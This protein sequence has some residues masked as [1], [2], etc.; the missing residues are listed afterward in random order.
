MNQTSWI[1]AIPLL[2]GTGG[3]V[4][5]ASP[6]E[7]QDIGKHT[8]TGDAEITDIERSPVAV[9]VVDAAKFH[10]R[11]ISLNELLKRVA[12]VKVRQQGGLGSKSTIAIHGLEGKRIKIFVDGRPLNSPDGTFGIN[13]IP[14]QLI[15]R[16]EVYKGVVP[17]RF[18]GDSLGG[19]VNVVTREFE[20]SQVDVTYALGSY[21]MH[22]LAG[23]VKK[24]V[25]EQGIEVAA[26]GFFNRAANDYVMQSPYA[27]GLSIRRDHDAYEAF[28]VATGM[29]FHD[30]LFD[31][32]SFELVRYESEKEIQGIDK[33]IREAET[34][35]EVNI[36][37][38]QMV[39]EDLWVPG[40]DVELTLQY[41]DLH[42]HLDDQATTCY[43]FAGNAF[44]CPGAG[45][46]VNGIPHD[47]DDRQRD[48]RQD[49]HVDYR[50][51]R[52]NALGF[53]INRQH[54]DYEPDDPLASASLGYD[55]GAFPSEKTNTVYS[56]GWIST[57]LDDQ[58]I[59]DI[60]VKS[61]HYDYRITS[62]TRTLS[63]TPAQTHHSGSEFGYYVSTRYE[64]VPDLF[65]KASYEHAYR[66][67]SS[68]EI[69]GDGVSVVAASDL[70]PEQA[71]NV[72]LGLIFDRHNV[73]GMPWLKAEANVFYRDLQ[74]MI[75]LESGLLTASYVNLGEVRST[76]FEVE[77]QADLSESWYAYLNYTHQ[78]LKDRMK[79]RADGVANPTY[80]K[81]VPN[82]PRQ[83]GNLGLEY[84]HLG[85]WREDALFKVFWE[86]NWA[87]EYFYGWEL[88]RQQSRRIDAQLTHTAGVEYS[89]MDDSLILGLEVR[90]LGD[91]DVTDVFNY[92]LPGRTWHL[93]VRYTWLDF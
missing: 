14:V 25:E 28:T 74:D 45:G 51:S 86:M 81:S 42:S 67:P 65:L 6:D 31:E 38:A 69:F 10:G 87:D 9:S 23:V 22:R 37:G 77:V 24:H 57:V 12:G 91:E 44:T 47:S 83:F 61:Y 49:L 32:M 18:G 19:A 66:L 40:L 79:R 39:E 62:Q 55:I 70:Q 63:G 89:V 52:R 92:P 34:R 11:N 72:N 56:L 27:D 78:S 93:N 76:G 54:S 90:N 68:D 8:V 29:K 2:I 5:A 85:L 50:L 64:P 59:N 43:D 35:S 1:L 53:H 48:F 30:R 17:A 13:D 41:I 7:S 82:V 16:I 15:E 58:L 73:A 3:Y 84:K 20:G 26:G 36:V 60:G 46:E 21:D 4:T 71:D 75:K 80:N 88:S 33:P